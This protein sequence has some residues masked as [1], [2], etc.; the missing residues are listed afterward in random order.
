MEVSACVLFTNPT[1]LKQIFHDLPGARRIPSESNSRGYL[2]GDSFA[3]MYAIP[4][5]MVGAYHL[6]DILE[7]KCLDR[8]LQLLHYYWHLGY[9]SDT[10]L[11]GQAM[12]RIP[13]NGEEISYA[14]S[15]TLNLKDMH[16]LQEHIKANPSKKYGVICLAW[17]VPCWK[18]VFGDGLPIIEA[19]D[20]DG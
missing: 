15:L 16:L 14:V 9:K 18:A 6:F 2:L 20:I 12:V 3:A 1:H 7:H 4:I 17:Q 13:S 5:N 19:P 11:P 8:E 10:G